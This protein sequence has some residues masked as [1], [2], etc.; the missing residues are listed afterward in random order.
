MLDKLG[1][2]FAVVSLLLGTVLLYDAVS[3]SDLTGA[4]ALAWMV[5]ADDT[6]SALPMP[7]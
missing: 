6:N 2:S 4:R 5:P 1:L 7:S 3:R